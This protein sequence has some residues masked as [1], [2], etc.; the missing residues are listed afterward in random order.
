MECADEP[1]RKA[2]VGPLRGVIVKMGKTRAF[3]RLCLNGRIA[4]HSRLQHRRANA[5]FWDV[6]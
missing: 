6:R 3:A 4:R 1:N 5:S 2:A